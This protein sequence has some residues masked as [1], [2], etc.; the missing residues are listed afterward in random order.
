MSRATLVG[1]SVSVLGTL[2]SLGLVA[3]ARHAAPGDAKA[4]PWPALPRYQAMA[5]PADNPMAAA[6]VALGRTLFFDTRLSGDGSVACVSCHRPE[7]GLTDGRRRPVGAHG[8]VS[9]RACP[10]LWNVG[11][12]QAFFWEGSAP[13]M[14]AAITGVWRFILAPSGPGRAGV[15]EVVARLGAVPGYPPLFAAAFGEG[16]TAEN[17]PKALAAFLRTLVADR[18]PWVRF[19]NGETGPLGAAGR[20]GWAVFDGKAGCTDCHNGVLLTDLQYHNVGIGMDAAKPDLGRFGPTRED[21]H[22]GAFKTPTLLNVGR[23]APYFHDGRVPTLEEAVD[24]ML[25]G[26]RPNPY[27]DTALEPVRLSSAERADLLA[28]L[29][30]LTVDFEVAAPALPR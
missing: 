8:I 16:P 19:Q 15:P 24:L 12:Q 23:S 29:R 5:V 25:A 6:K 30:A 1:L 11:Y 4:R 21:R 14:E 20:R 26:G 2:S 13:T 28:F 27:L 10:T 9:E 18:S 22:R 3:A 17:V 7:H